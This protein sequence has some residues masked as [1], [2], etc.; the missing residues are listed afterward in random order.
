MLLFTHKKF[1]PRVASLVVSVVY[2][3]QNGLV[4]LGSEM[5]IHKSDE[6]DLQTVSEHLA[7]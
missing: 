1:S 7:T 3:I 5:I 2:F 6:D 4:I